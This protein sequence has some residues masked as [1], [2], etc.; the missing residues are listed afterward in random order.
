MEQNTN[1]TISKGE[2]IQNPSKNI[3]GEIAKSIEEKVSNLLE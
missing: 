1:I 2:N 3:I